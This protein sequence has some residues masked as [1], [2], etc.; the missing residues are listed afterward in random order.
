MEKAVKHALRL[1]RLDCL[2]GDDYESRFSDSLGLLAT[3]SQ[4]AA[5]GDRLKEFAASSPMG[6]SR[7][8]L[9][10]SLWL[11]EAT[12]GRGLEEASRGGGSVRAPPNEASRGGDLTAMAL[13]VRGLKDL[14]RGG[15]SVEAP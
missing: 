6:F 12:G 14:S 13:R 2:P 15:D 1:A 5:P 11:E 10:L 9:A 8:A 4:A 3:G 7:S